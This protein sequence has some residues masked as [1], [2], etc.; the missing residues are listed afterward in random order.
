MYISSWLLHTVAGISV[1]ALIAVI[2]FLHF[3][4]H[5]SYRRIR[6]LEQLSRDLKKC[7]KEKGGLA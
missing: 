6:L 5:E 7:V 2:V 4:I 1:G 3:Y